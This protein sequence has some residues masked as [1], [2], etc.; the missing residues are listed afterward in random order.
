VR[1]WLRDRPE[2]EIVVVAHADI[3]RYIT[4][5]MNSGEPWGNTEVKEYT[6]LNDGKDADAVMIPFVATRVVSG[7]DNRPTGSRLWLRHTG[8]TVLVC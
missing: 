7:G 8:R 1:R 3:L 2:R 4:E 6:F 5:G